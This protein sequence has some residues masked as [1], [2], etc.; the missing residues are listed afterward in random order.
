MH[1]PERCRDYLFAEMARMREVIRLAGI[2]L[3]L[4]TTN[5]VG[6]I[7]T[8]CAAKLAVAR[9]LDERPGP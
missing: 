4:S 8:V 6:D 9:I 7:Q 2:A 3:D 1:T 5:Y